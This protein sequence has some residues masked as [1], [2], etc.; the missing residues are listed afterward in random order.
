MLP[1]IVTTFFQYTLALFINYCLNIGTPINHYFPFEANE[2]S[3]VS[4]VPVLRHFRVLDPRRALITG[5]HYG[6][7]MEESENLEMEDACQPC[8][9]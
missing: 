3:V 7:I 8:N 1:K 9:F 2:K 5:K 6:I 4:G